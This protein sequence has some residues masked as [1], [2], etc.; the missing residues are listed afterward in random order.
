MPLCFGAK[1]FDFVLNMG[2]QELTAPGHLNCQDAAPTQNEQGASQ[3]T[4]A[5]HVNVFYCG[6]LCDYRRYSFYLVYWYKSTKTDTGGRVYLSDLVLG[7]GDTLQWVY[8][9][10]EAH[11]YTIRVFEVLKTDDLHAG[12]G[13]GIGGVCLVD[14]QGNALPVCTKF[15]TTQYLIYH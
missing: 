4:D 10:G 1:E 3:N 15:T 7:A 2:K 14:G 12:D 5:M 13:L 6:A 9:L 8:D 11:R